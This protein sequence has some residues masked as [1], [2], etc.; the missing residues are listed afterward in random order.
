MRVAQAEHRR[1]PH[2]LVAVQ[3]RRELRG[4]RGAEVGVVE[5]P[6]ETERVG[7]GA[8]ELEVDLDRARREPAA[9]RLAAHSA[10]WKSRSAGVP[11]MHTGSRRRM[12]PS[13]IVSGTSADG[14]STPTAVG[15]RWLCSRSPT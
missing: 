9:S 3:P 15:S 1:Q 4:E 6:R 2:A 5:A 12:S 10:A 11:T 13:A 14:R 8:I 7:V